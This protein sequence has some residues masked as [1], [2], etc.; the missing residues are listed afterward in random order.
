M[1]KKIV[2]AYDHRVQRKFIDK[3]A[4]LLSARGV[5]MLLIEDNDSA[6]DYPLIVERAIKKKQEDGADGLILLCG[7][8]TG[9]NIVANKYD[10]IRSALPF[11]EV[12][13]FYARRH[14]DI[15]CICFGTGVKYDAE[16]LPEIKP[17]CRRKMARMIDTFLST[18]FEGERHARRVSQIAEIEKNN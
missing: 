13:T 8:G 2:V 12:E 9:M 5:E 3:I 6:N 4:E 18:E 15:N 7:S 14:E 1:F 16:D 10:G 11:G 17:V